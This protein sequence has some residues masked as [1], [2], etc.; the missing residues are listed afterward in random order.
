MDDGFELRE[1]EGD[2]EALV[3][4]L[5]EAEA[6]PEREGEGVAQGEAEPEP[7]REGEGVA[8]GEA[9]LEPERE[10]EDELFPLRLSVW[11]AEVEGVVLEETELDREALG[12]PEKDGFVDGE[13]P[14]VFV[15][16]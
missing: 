7:E 16:E 3:V 2:T 14:A 4:S 11:D 15:L 1:Y 12:L 10:G 5:A 13:S 8:Q 6:Q 9:E